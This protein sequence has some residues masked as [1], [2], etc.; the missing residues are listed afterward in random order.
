MKA[1][2]VKTSITGTV[3]VSKIVTIHDYEF[4]RNFVFH[5]ERHNFWEMVYID[6]GR[7]L[8]RC[9]EEEMILS[10][11]DI[12]FHSP[13]EFHAIRALDCAPN[14]FVISFVSNSPAM[15]YF[16][17]YRTTLDKTLKPFL[18]SIIRE[19]EAVYV[20]PKNDTAVK[21]LIKKENAA[22]GG[23]Q[24]IKTYLEQL[25]IFMIR[26]MVQNSQPA[27]FPSKASMEGHIVTEIKTLAE[28]R[29]FERTQVSDICADLGY[30]KSYLSRLFHEQTGDTI[31][32]YLQKSKIR[33]AKELI[34]GGVLNFTQISDQL[35]FDN[36]QY[37][38]RTF[39]R[40]TGMTP[41]QFKRS[42]EP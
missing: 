36:P 22:I 16:E 10:Q 28:Q 21:K 25:L 3:N 39:K 23:E 15:Q 32:A 33:K 4:D 9:G 12:V 29:V 20:I 19:S 35:A 7:V 40:I 2:Y 42:L 8:V 1:S 18:S 41:T 38:A 30:S 27:L 34:R 37:F 17:K 6:K 31:A 14:F 11:G 5:G 24:L 26:G 13:N